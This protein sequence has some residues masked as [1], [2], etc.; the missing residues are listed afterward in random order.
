MKIQQGCSL[1]SWCSLF[2]FHSSLISKLI[3]G[4][5]SAYFGFLLTS[6]LINYFVPSL[7][8]RFLSWLQVRGF[9]L[10]RCY[11]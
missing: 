8:S 4:K 3:V 10:A 7:G 5:L 11:C 1:L 9:S 2:T 6:G